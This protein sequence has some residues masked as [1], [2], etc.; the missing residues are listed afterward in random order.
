MAEQ[1]PIVFQ[2]GHTKYTRR[3]GRDALRGYCYGRRDCAPG[4]AALGQRARLDYQRH[5]PVCV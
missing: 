3:C 2:H 1:I 5:L 4:D